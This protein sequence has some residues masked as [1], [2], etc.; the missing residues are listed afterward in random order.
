[1]D[2]RLGEWPVEMMPKIYDAL[3]KQLP[4]IPY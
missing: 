4:N 2:I 1:M 3:K